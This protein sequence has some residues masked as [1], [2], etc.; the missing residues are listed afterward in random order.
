MDRFTA[1]LVDDE[2]LARKELRSMLAE[3]ETIDVVGEAETVAQAAELVHTQ[4]PDIIFLDIQLPGETGFDLVEKLPPDCRIIFVTAFD[5][6]AIRA[7]EVNALDY[8]LKPINPAR[9]AH[10]I[11]RVA[12]HTAAPAP[13]VRALEYEDRLLI[14]V[15]ERSRFL[16]VSDI[17]VI[18]AMGDYSQILSN[19]GQKS[20]VL[21]SLKD[22][23]ERLPAR[24]FT[25]IHR[26]TIINVEYVERL[27]SWFNRSYRIHIR[28]LAE[29]LVMS[30]RYAARFKTTFG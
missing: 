7:F 4:N 18:S 2:R 12:T 3:H 23:E 30:R 5:A 1:I 26:S 15:D 19:D 27:E 25:R 13:S 8:L 28:Q 16:K 6:Y 9:L 24:H 11:E 29:P 10:A 20:L 21:K 14:E 22:W 17:V